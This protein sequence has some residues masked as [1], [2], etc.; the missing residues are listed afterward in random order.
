MLYFSRGRCE[1]WPGHLKDSSH[2]GTM[3]VASVKVAVRV[4]P[5]NA[6]EISKESKCIIQMTGNTTSKY[7][8]APEILYSCLNEPWL[9]VWP[10]LQGFHRAVIFSYCGTVL[11]LFIKLEV[12]KHTS[13]SYPTRIPNSSLECKKIRAI[14][15][16]IK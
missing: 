13:E 4:R 16:E 5:F 12:N 14:K 10:H 11:N 7:S 3:A 1:H 2:R 6:R 9:S 8:T 15:Q